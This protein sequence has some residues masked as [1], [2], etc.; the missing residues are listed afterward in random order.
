MCGIESISPIANLSSSGTPDHHNI[1]APQSHHLFST[2][3]MPLD[4]QLAIHVASVAW[5][6]VPFNT[7]TLS[8][9]QQTPMS[10]SEGAKGPGATVKLTFN[11]QSQKTSNF[12]K[13]PGCWQKWPKALTTASM[14]T[15]KCDIETLQGFKCISF[16]LANELDPNEEDKGNSA[17]LQVKDMAGNL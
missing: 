15:L 13:G 11:G 17:I 2:P 4:P 14:H 16:N 1:G 3:L 8:T 9:G 12:T 10:Q 7:Q 5:N 6:P